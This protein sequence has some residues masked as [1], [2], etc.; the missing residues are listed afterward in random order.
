MNLSQDVV[1][2]ILRELDPRTALELRRCNKQL[3][4]WVTHDQLYWY[5]Q[6]LGYNGR[7][8]PTTRQSEK[9]AA[10][11]QKVHMKKWTLSCIDGRGYCRPDYE[12]AYAWLYEKNPLVHAEWL[13]AIQ[14]VRQRYL[15]MPD[16][17]VEH[18]GKV[19]VCI[20]NYQALDHNFCGRSDHFEWAYGKKAEVGGV[21][22]E[23]AEAKTETEGLFIFKFLFQ[24]YRDTR[25]TVARIK[26]EERAAAEA[27][28]LREKIMLLESQ[29]QDAKKQL[30][31]R[32][33]F[34]HL[35]EAVGNSVFNRKSEKR[36][37]ERK[38][39]KKT[40]E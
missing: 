35:K 11:A 34:P 29:I 24:C 4:R 28:A 14:V 37:H 27:Q 5:Y 8:Y 1:R 22:R 23:F 20:Q 2:L 32:E 18:R 30:T 38:E 15:Q 21:T 19:A 17:W 9:A 40:F 3:N 12:A 16:E 31:V 7:K 26:T 13:A 36:Y 25:K 6:T 10:K 39:V 33:N